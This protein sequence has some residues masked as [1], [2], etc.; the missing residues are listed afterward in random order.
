[1]LNRANRGSNLRIEEHLVYPKEGSCSMR[2]LRWLV[3][4]AALL[5]VAAACGDSGE[6][7]VSGEGF[8]FGMILVGP[9][10]DRGWSQA[11]FE[12]GDDNAQDHGRE[13]T[14]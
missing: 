11:H 14:E 10:N 12:G 9:Q 7:E 3:P 5:L 4:I 2:R 1:M 6:E 13:D 8:K